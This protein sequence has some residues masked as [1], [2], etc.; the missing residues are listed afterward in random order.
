MIQQDV[1]QN[2]FQ[3]RRDLEN[4]LMDL[5]PDGDPTKIQ[6]Y[7]DLQRKRDQ[8]FMTINQVIAADFD[9]VFGQDVET[10]LKN[11]AAET[12]SIQKLAT[13]FQTINDVIAKVDGVIKMAQD[14]VAKAARVLAPG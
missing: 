4:R 12:S 6:Q 11:L 13:T 2:L 8:V 14:V 1:L 5:T 10:A 9:E 7:A 3:V